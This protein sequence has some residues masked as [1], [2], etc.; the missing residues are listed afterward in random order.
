[1]QSSPAK[2]SWCWF[3]DGARVRMPFRLFFFQ[4]SFAWQSHKHPSENELLSSSSHVCAC[5]HR[6]AWPRCDSWVEISSRPTS[7]DG[8]TRLLARWNRASMPGTLTGGTAKPPQVG[9]KRSP[10]SRLHL[11]WVTA[12]RIRSL[13]RLTLII[14][15]CGKLHISSDQCFCGCRV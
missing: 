11:R 3:L 10:P 9:L 6:Q 2:S 1:M 5:Y 7:R 8:P 14:Q 15:L 4:F 12:G 13:S